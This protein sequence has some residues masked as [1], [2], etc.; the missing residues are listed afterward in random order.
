MQ[1]RSGDGIKRFYLVIGT[2]K[3]G[4]GRGVGGLN[5]YNKDLIRP[6]FGSIYPTALRVLM[7]LG[8]TDDEHLQCSMLDTKLST[9]NPKL[10][11]HEAFWKLRPTVI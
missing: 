4:R 1:W 6:L 3:G 10:L 2:L 5:A 7:I 11:R 8:C 9:S